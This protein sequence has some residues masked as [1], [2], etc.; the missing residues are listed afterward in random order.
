[1]QVFQIVNN[2]CFQIHSQ[3]HSLAVIEEQSVGFF[4]VCYCYLLTVQFSDW[5]IVV[6]LTSLVFCLDMLSAYCFQSLHQSRPFGSRF[7]RIVTRS[8]LKKK[9]PRSKLQAPLSEIRA[10]FLRPQKCKLGKEKCKGV[11]RKHFESLNVKNF[12]HY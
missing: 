10:C 6:L 8:V 5:K 7:I 11:E 12:K 4:C 1:M 3:F 2:C 9:R